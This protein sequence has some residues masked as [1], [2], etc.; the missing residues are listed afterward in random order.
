LT[1]TG[2]T[3]K[4]NFGAR[5]LAVTSGTVQPTMTITHSGN[6]VVISWP[7]TFQNYSLEYKTDL[8]A[9][10]WTSG[11][12]ATLNGGNFEVIIPSG[13]GNQFFRLKSP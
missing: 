13:T 12:A 2:V 3:Y 5:I 11:P 4:H 9:A 1:E 6:N 7:S 8:N 10:A